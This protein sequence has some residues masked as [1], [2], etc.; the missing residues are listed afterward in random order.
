MI[1]EGV[2][3]MREE[4]FAYRPP[5]AGFKT[6]LARLYVNRGRW[7]KRS[8]WVLLL[9]A[10]L[11]AGYHYLYVMPAERGQSRLAQELIHQATGQQEAMSTLRE[12]KPLPRPSKPKT[13]RP[14]PRPIRRKK[15]SHT[16]RIRCLCTF[17]SAT[18]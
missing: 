6:A 14:G 18:S 16:E 3:A 10:A 5:P 15:A 13:K 12:L 7:A 2:K 11:W 4:R 9:L 8:V 17:G 1:A